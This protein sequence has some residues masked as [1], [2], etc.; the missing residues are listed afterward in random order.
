MYFLVFAF[1]F[2]SSRRGVARVEDGFG[3]CEGGMVMWYGGLNGLGFDGMLIYIGSCKYGLNILS[4]YVVA[5]N[6]DGTLNIDVVAWNF[7][8]ENINCVGGYDYGFM[9]ECG[10]CYEVMC[11]VGW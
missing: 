3:W 7:N 2:V 10:V 5:L 8:F 1:A 11:V 6:I 9:D 4:Y